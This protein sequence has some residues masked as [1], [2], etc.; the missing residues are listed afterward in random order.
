M[1]EQ[2]RQA[3]RYAAAVRRHGLCIACQFRQGFACKG[4]PQR[5]HGECKT[6]QLLPKFRLDASVMARF[7][8]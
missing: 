1:S 3:K 2:D 8:D 6:D 7:L 4:Y 5:S